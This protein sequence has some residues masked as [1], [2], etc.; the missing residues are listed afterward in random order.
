M[1]RHGVSRGSGRSAGLQCH[2]ALAQNARATTAAK[3]KLKDMHNY[4]YLHRD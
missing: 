3:G 4:V 2:R 1:L